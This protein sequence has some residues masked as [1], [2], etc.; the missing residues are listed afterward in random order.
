MTYKTSAFWFAEGDMRI[1]V[2]SVTAD[3]CQLISEL[4]TL[5]L[6]ELLLPLPFLN[7]IRI[8]RRRWEELN[9]GVRRDREQVDT[10]ARAMAPKIVHQ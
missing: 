1:G 10:G 2:R 7:L 8:A 4:I 9:S 5:H 6:P 3:S